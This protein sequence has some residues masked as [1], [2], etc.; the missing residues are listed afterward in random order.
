M[1]NWGD[2]ACTKLLLHHIISKPLADVGHPMQGIACLQDLEA[3]FFPFLSHRQG[4]GHASGS[5]MQSSTRSFKVRHRS[6]H[7]TYNTCFFSQQRNL[8]YKERP[9]I[10]INAI[11]AMETPN[12]IL[13]SLASLSNTFVFDC[14]SLSKCLSIMSGECAVL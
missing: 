10:M 3:P 12:I 6:Q 1:L 14:V 2:G 11:A 7:S 13:C 8:L 4:S 5:I 9:A